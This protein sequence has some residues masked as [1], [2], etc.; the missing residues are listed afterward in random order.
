M[1][2]NVTVA[3]LLVCALVS[4]GAAQKKAKTWTE[5]SKKDAEK[6]LNDSPWGQTQVETDTSEMFFQP[7]SPG[8]SGATGTTRSTEGATNQE[9]NIKYYVRFFSARPIRMA[10]A[11]IVALNN[12]TM[13]AAEGLKKF[14]EYQPTDITIVTVWFDSTDQR[15]GGKVLQ[16]LSSGE[17]STLQQDA[18]LER[19]DG[20]R[21]FLQEYVKPGKDGFGARFIFPRKVDGQPFLTADS[22][23][24]R[25][26]AE[27]GSNKEF[28]IDRRFKLADMMYEGALEY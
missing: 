8:G 22:G 21:L 28:K 14:A 10:L 18:Y 4:G 16:A 5:W 13:Q 6:I 25:F 11:R 3:L 15:S 23:E 20:K 1:F 7:T 2:K 27:L 9:I 26:H 12:P 24:V 17:T 19:K